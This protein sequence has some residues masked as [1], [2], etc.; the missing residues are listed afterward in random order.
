MLEKQREL[1]K[2]CQ[3]NNLIITK[4]LFEH[5]DIHKEVGGK[6]MSVNNYILIEE[7]NTNL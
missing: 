1:L 7:N 2:F 3:K 6:E 5:K 4:T